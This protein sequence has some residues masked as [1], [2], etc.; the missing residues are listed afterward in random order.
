[1][2]EK[3]NPETEEETVPNVFRYSGEYWD[4]T[5]NLQYLRAR[6]YDPNTGRF[7]S[8]DPYQGSLDNPL[9]LNRYSYVSNS[10]L[11]YVDPSGYRQEWGAGVGGDTPKSVWKKIGDGAYQI[12]DFY[13]MGELSDYVDV[14]I[15]GRILLNIL[16]WV[17]EML[18]F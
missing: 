15:I 9:S 6:W 1:M 10:P 14:S 8:K 7:V 17:R 11:K 13:T 16:L 18:W 12:V 3:G 2:V 5:T 4:S